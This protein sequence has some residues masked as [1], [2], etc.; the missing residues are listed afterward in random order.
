MTFAGD[1]VVSDS[2]MYCLADLRWSGQC[3]D[4]RPWLWRERLRCVCC[5]QA[6]RKAGQAPG[7]V[8][9]LVMYTGESLVP[10]AHFSTLEP[11]KV[12][13]YTILAS[14]SPCS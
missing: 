5:R 10:F 1:K 6:R 3:L 12:L 4:W 14:H 9:C 13:K 2:K 8:T 11:L 7:G